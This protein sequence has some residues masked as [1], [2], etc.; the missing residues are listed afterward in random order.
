[1]FFTQEDYRKIEKW[2]LA[3][4][5][6][7]TDFAGAATP[8]KGNETVVLVQNGKNVKASVKDVVEQLFLLGVSDF[9]NITDKYGE[10]YISLSQAIELIP[11]RSRKV[12]QV[13]TFLDDTGKWA[14]YQFQGLRKNQWNTLSLWIDLI[15]LMKGMTVVDSEDIVT[16]T[17]SANQ[18]SL[19]FA[20][21]TYNEADYSGLGRI[22][23]RKNVVNVEDP[24][25]GNT[26]TINLLQQSMISK[27]NTT[28]ILQYDYNLNK[29]IL[30]VPSGSVLL[31]EG[32]SISNGT[33]ELNNTI[34]AGNPLFKDAISI[35]GTINNSYLRPEWF[36]ASS[37]SKD[38]TKAINNALYAAYILG[39]EVVRLRN[40]IYN[41]GGT[42]KI[43][44]YCSLIGDN[45]SNNKYSGTQ[46]IKSGIGDAITFARE[47]GD[48]LNIKVKDLSVVCNT[49]TE[50]SGIS[51]ISDIAS[52]FNCTF[53]GVFI[54][55]FKIGININISGNLGIGYNRFEKCNIVY[56]N[57]GINIEGT[58]IANNSPWCNY[59]SFV[60]NE[61]N[62]HVIGGV[63]IHGVTSTQEID[64]TNN[65]FEGIGKDYT[66]DLLNTFPFLG[67]AIKVDSLYRRGAIKVR[68]N[69]IEIVYP[70][71][72][73]TPT[74]NEYTV[75]GRVFPNRIKNE[76]AVLQFNNCEAVIEANF[77]GN[78]CTPVRVE[79]S[80]GL[81]LNS[82][83]Y[84]MNGLIYANSESEL[85]NYLVYIN[86]SNFINS[87]LCIKE[88][89]SNNNSRFPYTQHLFEND[90]VFDNSIIL[91]TDIIT[92]NQVNNGTTSSNHYNLSNRQLDTYK[93]YLDSS[94][95]NQVST[96]GLSPITAKPT[97]ASIFSA[98]V[99][100]K[101][102]INIDIIGDSIV[103]DFTDSN[104]I[105]K[106]INVRSKNKNKLSY[107]TNSRTL[108]VSR[109]ITFDN[110]YIQN[111]NIDYPY[112]LETVED[113]VTI[114]FI[115]CTIEYSNLGKYL[116][117][118]APNCTINLINC[119]FVTSAE[120]GEFKIVYSE[121]TK[122]F[123]S[124][125]TFQSGYTYS[126][127]NFLNEDGTLTT[128]VV[129]V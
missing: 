122:V 44:P 49:S 23:L 100:Y 89:Q 78:F 129:I 22:Y 18:T 79:G 70:V 65:T 75:G 63:Y 29:Q 28:Y 77:I 93:V 38:N 7:D 12:G 106:D 73:G 46:I 113:S 128:R 54:K 47:N 97:F 67:F 120:T 19:K 40:T 116:V 43:Y 58:S 87:F 62:N 96:L 111:N 117:K 74:S 105:N 31:F 20:N 55:G 68:D 34:L 71:R 98:P 124:N 1:M 56:C 41:I 17:N 90:Y 15:D 8:L 25:T 33:L 104:V 92:F 14:M 42:L 119:N 123:M 88:V 11:Y 69:Y 39:V 108:K 53:E 30:S 9:V 76:G 48:F 109:D 82:N 36:G 127:E 72:T 2:L 95:S 16:E 37:T 86:S 27:E 57:I 4:S 126:E 110:L 99:I 5:R 21:K 13:I 50:Y 10:S 64:F 6:K 45:E 114:N 24:I 103:G 121:G 80:F 102:T 52:L 83:N 85:V 118:A 3:N 26:I 61:I 91:S 35:T 94:K 60:K 81:T 32:G 115:N 84:E 125:T 101:G 51:A 59:N 112:F 107:S 66:V